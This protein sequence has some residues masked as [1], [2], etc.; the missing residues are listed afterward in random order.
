MP[1]FEISVGCEESV[2]KISVAGVVGSSVLVMVS[3]D[4]V[5]SVVSSAYVVLA[6]VAKRAV[7]KITPQSPYAFDLTN[8]SLIF[9][10]DMNKSFSI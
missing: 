3:V 2:A 9:L 10:F 1:S 4:G 8:P 7:V 6:N 5:V